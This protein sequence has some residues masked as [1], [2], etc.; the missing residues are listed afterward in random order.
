MAN[1]IKTTFQLK[2]GTE[3]RWIEVN[4]I[5]A[6]GEPGYEYDKNRLKIGDGI[7]RWNELDYVATGEAIAKTEEIITVENFSSLPK[8][9]DETKLYRVISNKFLYQWV[10]DKYEALGG[11]GS[12]DPSTITLI[13]G[14]NA[15]G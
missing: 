2:R 14:G 3:Q 9:G 6:Q 7:R 4:P 1:I 5:L 13:N 8:V 10:S 12:F 15:N 11:E